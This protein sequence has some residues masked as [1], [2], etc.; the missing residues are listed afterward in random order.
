MAS[1][2]ITH[3]CTAGGPRNLR[4]HFHEAEHQTFAQNRGSQTGTSESEG[5]GGNPRLAEDLCF[6]LFE[7]ENAI[8]HAGRCCGNAQT[9]YRFIHRLVRKPE[10]SVVHGDHSL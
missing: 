8:A 5:I 3:Y 4:V 7:N 1:G 9:L 10:G 2:V 6:P